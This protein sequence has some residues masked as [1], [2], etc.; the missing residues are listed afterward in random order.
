MNPQPIGR[1]L[2]MPTFS[3]PLPSVNRDVLVDYPNARRRAF[4]K[5]NPGIIYNGMWTAGTALDESNPII[6]SLRRSQA[7]QATFYTFLG[8]TGTGK[9]CACLVGAIDQIVKNFEEHFLK[10]KGLERKYDGMFIK[11]DDISN[12]LGVSGVP[13]KHKMY[14]TAVLIIDELLSEKEGLVT[15]S[16]IT[17]VDQ[18]IDY[19]YRHKKHTFITSNLNVE[20]FKETYGKRIAS[21][22]SESGS[23]GVFNGEDLRKKKRKDWS[24]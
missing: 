17:F 5:L 13:E 22:L 10:T 3:S 7:T 15:K 18:L 12:A 24:A 9:T 8:E 16:F 2:T 19:R 23:L 21:R 6:A 11:P 4:E 14:N 20:Q 1:L